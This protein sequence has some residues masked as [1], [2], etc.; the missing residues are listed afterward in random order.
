MS[1]PMSHDAE[2]AAVIAFLADPRTHDAPT[3]ER[4]DTHG[5][6]VFIACDHAWKLKRAVRFAY[7]DFSTLAKRRSACQAEQRLNR[8]TAPDIYLAVEAVMRR[9]DGTLAVG[10][11]GEEVDWLVVM[12]RIDQDT[13]FDR[14]AERGALTPDLMRGL[15]DAIAD[16]H[17]GAERRTDQGGADA[18]RRVIDDNMAE[19]GEH[20]DLFPSDR[21]AHLADRSRSA[22]EGGAALLDRRRD[23]G[24]VRFCHG[25]LHLRNIC[26][27]GGRPTL[28]DCI[29]FNDEIA[30]I[31]VLYDLAFLIMDLEH[32]GLRPLAG[33][34][35]NRYL[36][37][38]GDFDGLALLPLFL[39]VR[40]AVRAKVDASAAAAQ[41]DPE[42]VD[43]LRRSASAYF[44][45]AL[46]FLETPRP[47]LI[48]VGGL[49][50]SGKT[51]LAR[52]LA[53]D[54]GPVPG[55]VVL[56]SDVIRKQ[57]CGV[58]ETDR[59]PPERYDE[60]TTR[61]VYDELA[62]RARRILKA[63]HAV[64][65]DAV[66]ARAEERAVLERTA[67]EAGAGFLGLWLEARPETLLTRIRQRVNDASDATEDVV[68]RQL[69]YATGPINWTRIDAD[70]DLVEI[71]T[72]VRSQIE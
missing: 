70:C 4:V 9:P 6:V 10:G 65:V 40:A 7:M 69:A 1:M 30:I 5:S 62:V 52:R 50:G 67:A 38:T 61:R 33:A 48:G 13:L 59:L 2:Q 71:S 8:R 56:R 23:D 21:I 72:K 15:A 34:L 27:F 44:A 29:E 18:L 68:Q 17:G 46:T 11:V 60:A 51:T 3:V 25:D 54:V 55:A 16:F 41:P 32:R 26:L 58:A 22:L 66:N 24:F 35:F 57:L 53:S 36:E 37:R 31:D 43:R 28:F 64:I 42:Q 49:S 20:P 12:R 63:G 14:M 47:L 19:L 45:H 39:S